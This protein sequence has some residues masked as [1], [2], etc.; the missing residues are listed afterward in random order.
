MH[1]DT[2]QTNK[3]S[4]NCNNNPLLIDLDFRDK[5]TKRIHK[6]ELWF[7]KDVFKNLENENDADY[8]LDKMI[9]RFKEKGGHVLGQEKE[10]ANHD[11]EKRMQKR[12]VNENGDANSDYDVEE[13]MMPKKKTKN[14]DGKDGFEIVSRETGNYIIKILCGS[15][16]VCSFVIYISEILLKLQ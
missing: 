10:V 6:A 5:N 16:S 3:Q 1:A 9:E 2:L 15:I 8:E 13:I 11:K 7:Q 4:A 14:V 12:K